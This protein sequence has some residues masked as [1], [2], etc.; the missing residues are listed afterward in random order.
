MLAAGDL[1]AAG[2]LQFTSPPVRSRE[3]TARPSGSTPPATPAA[4]VTVK[5]AA[6]DTFT[7]DSGS[8]TATISDVQFS[9]WMSKGD[10]LT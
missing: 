6:G 3:S 7:Y 1:V 9:N 4:D 8:T 5:Y 2:P 10:R